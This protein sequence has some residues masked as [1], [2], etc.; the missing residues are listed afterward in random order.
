M[1]CHD[2]RVL[3]NEMSSDELRAPGQL[4]D[5]HIKG[6]A[7]CRSTY[8][9]RLIATESMAAKAAG[10]VAGDDLKR[11]IFSALDRE[12]GEAPAPKGRW[13]FSW[14]NLLR[15]H[16]AWAA[17]A[18]VLVLVSGY[19]YLRTMGYFSPSGEMPADMARF[20]ADVGHDAF[21]QTRQPQTFELVTHDPRATRTW[22]AD[23]LDFPV[24]AP[25]ELPGGYTIGGVR[26]WHTV[27]RL[28]ALVGYEGPGTEPVS[29]FVI[30]SANLADS[31]GQTVRQ[32]N[33]TFHVGESF[34]FN[35]VAWQE[36][37]CAYALVG[38]LSTD[39][40]LAMAA[41]FSE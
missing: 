18:T 14:R 40:L 25:A 41:S 7:S 2:V 29:L 13:A 19:N 28:S 26:L 36:G 24:R 34:Q 11:R 16:P 37:P 8:R 21:L 27:S 5:G 33:R 1:K 12:T 20:V 23:R 32:G 9:L 17:L 39:D 31:S 10:A 38:L 4:V 15:P 22:F 6:C 35:V 3:I 30:S